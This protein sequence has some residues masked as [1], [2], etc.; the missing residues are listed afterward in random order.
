M[1]EF[2]E[3]QQAVINGKSREAEALTRKALENGIPA[4]DISN[5]TL[6][7][8]MAVVGQRMKAGEY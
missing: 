6:I 3:L 5:S 7:T 8:A 4:L 1:F 2:S